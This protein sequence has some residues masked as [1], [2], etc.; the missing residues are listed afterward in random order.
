MKRRLV[1][2]F[3]C[4]AA[5]AV[6]A[7]LAF[8]DSRYADLEKIIARIAIPTEHPDGD[9]FSAD[10]SNWIGAPIVELKSE[11]YKDQW[12]VFE[13]TRFLVGPYGAR[14]TTEL[15]KKVR[16]NFQRYDDMQVFGYCF[17]KAEIKRAEQMRG[18]NPE[19][20]LCTPL[21]ENQITKEDCLRKIQSAGIRLPV[22]YELGY[23]NNNCIGCVKGG[24]GYWNKIRVDFPE[25]FLRMMEMEESIGHTV[26]RKDKKPLYLKNLDPDA[27]RYEPLESGCDLLCGQ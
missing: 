27:G 16:R 1:M 3:S 22:M 18:E 9:R 6:A 14:C 17:S 26:L 12:D 2:W 21:I 8:I 25:T 7:K 15:K 20:N 5:S 19:I 24:M 11:E 4:G 13:K 23:Q 10:V